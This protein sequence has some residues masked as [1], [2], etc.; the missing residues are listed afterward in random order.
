MGDVAN[1][2]APM[3]TSD[4]SL[5]VTQ[6]GKMVAAVSGFSFVNPAYR[7]VIVALNGDFDASGPLTLTMMAYHFHMTEKLVPVAEVKF[8]R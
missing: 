1:T 5:Y 6:D 7:P 2:N 3:G 4:R 8:S